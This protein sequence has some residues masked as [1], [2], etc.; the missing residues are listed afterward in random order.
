MLPIH[1]AP[2]QGYTEAPYRI[3]HNQV[4]GGIDSYYTPFIRLEHGQIRKKDLREAMPE[5]NQGVKVIPQVI[6]SDA[7]EFNQLCHKLLEIGH[8][9]IDINMGCPFPLQTRLGRGSG[10]W[11]HPDR[12]EAILAAASEL[13]EKEGI[14]FSLKMR[15]GQENPIE[16][17]DLLPVLNKTP[18]IHITVHPRV[19]RQQYKGEL[20]MNEFDFLYNNS[21]NPLIFNGELHTVDDLIEI[22]KNYPKLAGLMIGRGLLARP[23]L[24]AEYIDACTKGV[25]IG[26]GASDEAARKKVLQMHRQLF[27]YYKQHIEGGD[28]QLLLK[29]HS[30]WDYQ[31]L[32]FGHKVIKKILK[33]G[34]MKNYIEATANAAVK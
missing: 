10:I 1:F 8:K 26:T 27:D 14:D 28:S 33:S 5:H 6:A 15:L 13:H 17:L 31:E 21:S 12:V 34:S 4:C 9:R 30:F 19:G 20:L 25:V 32:L 16:A 3:I 24:A 29:M 2:L 7:D 22:E 23:T 11:Q 18:L